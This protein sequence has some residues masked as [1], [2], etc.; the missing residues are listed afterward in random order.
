MCAKVALGVVEL[1]K[2]EVD[3]SLGVLSLMC[4]PS[5]GASIMM[6]LLAESDVTLSAIMTSIN[7]FAS[8]GYTLNIVIFILFIQFHLLYSFI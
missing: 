3:T 5:E 8:T 2:P 4:S 7:N 1:F 6:V